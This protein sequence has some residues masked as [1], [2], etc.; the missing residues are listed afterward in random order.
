MNNAKSYEENGFELFS[1][2]IKEEFVGMRKKI[3]SLFDMIATAHGVGRVRNDEEMINLYSGP[4]NHL[5]RAVYDHLSDIPAI[6]SLAN[7]PEILKIA[8]ACGIREPASTNG[9]PV[10]LV[11]LP[12]DTVRIFPGHQDLTYDPGGSENSLVIWIP[13]QDIT[14]EIGPVEL[15]SGSHR[16][17][18]F[19][20]EDTVDVKKAG[21]QL[22]EDIGNYQPALVKVG[23]ALALSAFTVHKSGINTTGNIVKMSVHFRYRDLA[24]TEY[25]SRNLSKKPVCLEDKLKFSLNS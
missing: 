3:F 19:R 25:L 13:L 9:Q 2:G 18:L 14:P 11:G 1:L 21:I 5:W 12:G 8:T 24:S 7:H 4:N 20:H 22:P 23:E 16:H 15:I 17:G 10:I 6:A